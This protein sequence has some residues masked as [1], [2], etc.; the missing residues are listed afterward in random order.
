MKSNVLKTLIGKLSTKQEE[1]S[2]D[3]NYLVSQESTAS[4]SLMTNTQPYKDKASVT[5]KKRPK[6]RNQGIKC[7]L[8]EI[9]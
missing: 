7:D 5:F 4:D 1:E 9:L 2:K 8:K 6:R 3:D